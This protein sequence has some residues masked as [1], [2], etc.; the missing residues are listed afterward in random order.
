MSSPRVRARVPVWQPPGRRGGFRFRAA[1]AAVIALLCLGAAYAMWGDTP[2]AER[3]Q[4]GVG[5]AEAPRR[6]AIVYEDRGS[7]RTFE[8]VQVRALPAVEVE[9]LFEAGT[10]LKA[11]ETTTLRFAARD[12]ATGKPPRG[13]TTASLFHGS[14]PPVLLKVEEVSEGT[15]EVPVTPHGPGRFDVV[16]SVNGAPIGSQRLGVVGTVGG[17][18]GEED[19]LD[20]TADQRAGRARPSGRGR[21]R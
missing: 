20:F 1:M 7:I 3:E 11:E 18:S 12:R 21:T 13:V 8:R 6:P 2:A 17:T 10:H 4:R 15:F 14:D 19:F 9:P 5:I 16:L